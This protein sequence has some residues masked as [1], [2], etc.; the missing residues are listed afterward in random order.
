[1]SE[2]KRS[3]PTL[4]GLD[5]FSQAGNEQEEAWFRHYLYWE[6]DRGAKSRAQ[7]RAAVEPQG[8]GECPK[9]FFPKIF[10]FSG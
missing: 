2:D 8:S 10:Y 7:V 4:S 5:L 1:M 6:T 3:L 9:N